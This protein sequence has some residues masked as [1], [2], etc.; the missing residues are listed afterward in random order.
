M[1]IAF[2][3]EN[4]RRKEYELLKQINIDKVR[5]YS[6]ELSDKLAMT[7]KLLKDNRICYLNRFCNRVFGVRLRRMKKKKRSLDR[8]FTNQ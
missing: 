3:S 8:T 5:Y 7:K 1:F 6:N 4:E 2:I